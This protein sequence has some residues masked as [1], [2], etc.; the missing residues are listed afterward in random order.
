MGASFK[1]AFDATMRNEGGYANDPQDPEGEPALWC[2]SGRPTITS[3]FGPRPCLASLRASRPIRATPPGAVPRYGNTNWTSSTWIEAQSSSPFPLA[4]QRGSIWNWIA[5]T[6]SS[7]SLM[8]VVQYCSAPR[9][10][11]QNSPF[12]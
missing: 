1:P 10:V 6:R 5:F 12:R 2:R 4:S 8:R 9:E 11:P 7:T 3:G